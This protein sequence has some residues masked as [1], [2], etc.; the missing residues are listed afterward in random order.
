MRKLKYF[1]F[2]Y[3]GTCRFKLKS[4]ERLRKE[5]GNGWSGIS[6]T[7]NDIMEKMLDQ[8]YIQPVQIY[9]HQ[10]IYFCGWNW[11][12]DWFEWIR[13]MEGNM[14]YDDRDFSIILHVE[15]QIEK[16]LEDL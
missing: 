16:I 4:A 13:D 12:A 9:P 10:N 1:D 14:L 8:E 2:V 3:R 11:R 6:P 7:V 5:F 15:D